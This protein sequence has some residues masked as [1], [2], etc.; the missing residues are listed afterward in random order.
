MRKIEK[1]MCEAVQMRTNWSESNTI[2]EVFGDEVTVY[3]HGNAIYRVVDGVKYFTL[4]GWNTPTTRSRLHAL[5]VPVTQKHFA[6]MYNGVEIDS[7]RW[8]NV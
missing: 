6:P 8:Y 4:A 2:V 5:G 7:T 1:A 3:L